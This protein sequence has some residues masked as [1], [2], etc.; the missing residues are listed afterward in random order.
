LNQGSADLEFIENG[1]LAIIP[2]MIDGK[3]NAYKLD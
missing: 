1:K 3:V 2:M